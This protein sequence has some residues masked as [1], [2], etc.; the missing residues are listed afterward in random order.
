MENQISN[1]LMGKVAAEEE[2]ELNAEL[3]LLM[4][5]MSV[6]AGSAATQDVKK[7][8]T[9]AVT[10]TQVVLDLP[11]VPTETILPEVPTAPIK[12]NSNEEKLSEKAVEETRQPTAA[13]SS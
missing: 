7:A 11:A 3:E 9:I 5:S 6:T 13:V 2:D 10:Q 1:L 8:S 12:V 4:S